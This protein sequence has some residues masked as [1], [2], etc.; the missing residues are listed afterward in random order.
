MKQR[1]AENIGLIIPVEKETISLEDFERTRFGLCR[2]ENNG[3]FM[4]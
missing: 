2:L 4:R 1:A 3:F